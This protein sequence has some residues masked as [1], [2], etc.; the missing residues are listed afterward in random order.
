MTEKPELPALVEVPHLDRLYT[1]S[2]ARSYDRQAWWYVRNSAAHVC[3]VRECGDLG[4]VEWSAWE[5]RVDGRPMVVDIS[6][7]HT[8]GPAAAAGNWPWLRFCYTPMWEPFTRVGS[9]P[10]TSFLDWDEYESLS[11]L[12]ARIGDMIVYGQRTE[13]AGEVHEGKIA[14]RTRVRELLVASFR[15]RLDDRW[16]SVPSFWARAASALATVCIGGTNN[17]NLDRGQWQLMGLGC[18]TVS[19]EIFTAPLGVRPEAG[20]H[21]VRI[22]DDFSD[23]GA[24]IEGLIA[25]P[26]RAAAVGRAAAGFFRDRGVPGAIWAYAKAR[27][28]LP[29]GPAV[30][31]EAGDRVQC[32]QPA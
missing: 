26:A 31:D 19:P 32:V 2:P 21:Y 17:N 10:V 6:D 9:F 25:D 1:D 14:R 27:P 11:R 23:L 20:V 16:T 5:V 28:D 18:C 12:P 3:E 4:R 22:R 7:Y 13:Y 8:L 29:A 30:R 15:D 24:A